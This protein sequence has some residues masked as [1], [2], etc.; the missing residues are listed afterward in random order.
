MAVTRGVVVEVFRGLGP[1]RRVVVGNHL[2]DAST[3]S[4][5]TTRIAIATAAL[6]QRG[7][8]THHQDQVMT[9]QSFKT[10]KVTARSPANPMPLEEDD[11]S[12]MVVTK[13]VVVE[14]FRE[15]GRILQSVN[16]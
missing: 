12:D 11:E 4:N 13:L 8:R 16:F 14:V 2:F 9:P 10:M 1:G 6:I 15:Y 5:T 7:D 3:T